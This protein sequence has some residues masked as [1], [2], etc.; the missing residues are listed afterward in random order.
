MPV[1]FGWGRIQTLCN[2]W[3]RVCIYFFGPWSILTKS[4]MFNPIVDTLHSDSRWA[5]TPKFAQNTGKTCFLMSH[6]SPQNSRAK[7]G[8]QPKR[9]PNAIKLEC[10]LK[11]TMHFTCVKWFPPELELTSSTRVTST[12]SNILCCTCASGLWATRVVPEKVVQT[13]YY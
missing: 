4:S 10:F 9:V 7:K 11:P 12:W 3:L 13:G 2:F 6:L 5:K 8:S 1:P